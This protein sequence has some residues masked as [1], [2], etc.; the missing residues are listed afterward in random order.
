MKKLIPA[1]LLLLTA[2]GGSAQPQLYRLGSDAAAQATCTRGPSITIRQPIAAPG[3]DSAHIVVLQ[4]G[5]RQSFYNDVRWNADAPELVQHY[6]AGRF[7]QSGRFALVTTDDSAARTTWQLEIQLRDFQVDQVANKLQITFTAS[8]VNAASRR[9]VLTLP[10]RAE[11]D[12]SGKDMAGI[13]AGFDAQMAAL[14][15]Q[16]LAALSHQLPSCR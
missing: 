15:D 1:L 16:L 7:E 11:A 10:L 14:S 2:C 8:L 9:P 3:L 13:V 4:E 12:I 6:L 5:G